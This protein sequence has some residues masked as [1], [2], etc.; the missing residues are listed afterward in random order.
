MPRKLATA[1]KHAARYRGRSFNSEAT[2]YLARGSALSTLAAAEEHPDAPGAEAARKAA[3]EDFAR[4]YAPASRPTA[5]AAAYA[6]R[7]PRAAAVVAR[8]RDCRVVE[9]DAQP[10]PVPLP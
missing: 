3:D 1:V 5:F 4:L 6:G 8:L 9:A 2:L 10:D 7:E